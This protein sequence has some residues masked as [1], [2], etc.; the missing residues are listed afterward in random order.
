M[1]STEVF[2]GYI[3]ITNGIAFFA[4][5]WDKQQA[6]KAKW[7]TP[8][9][10]L[11]MLALAGGSIGAYL[12]MKIWKHKTLHKKFKYGLP[13]IILLQTLVLWWLVWY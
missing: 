1:L 2:I 10:R 8:E 6:K 7:R 9:N 3:A 5:G 12:G 11:I 4:F 13:L